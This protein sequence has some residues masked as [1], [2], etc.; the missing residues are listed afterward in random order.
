MTRAYY[1]PGGANVHASPKPDDFITGDA[2]VTIIQFPAP[3]TAMSAGQLVAIDKSSGT[4]ALVK[5]TG[6]TSLV[7]LGIM[8]Y[9]YDPSKPN[10]AKSVSIYTGGCFNPDRII[11]P[12][13]ITNITIQMIYV[14]G[15]P[16][17]IQH[18]NPR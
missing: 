6:G 2:P 12:G 10:A 16:I 11:W 7:I 9:D 14:A 5:H 4:G 15:S 1:L 18:P 13:G 3:T 17:F 8:V